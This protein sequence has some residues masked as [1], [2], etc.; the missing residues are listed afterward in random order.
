MVSGFRFIFVIFCFTAVLVLTVYLRSAKNQTF[1]KIC[2]INAEQNQLRQELW[3]R[4]IRLE[5]LMNPA[6]VSQCLDYIDN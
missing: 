6:A 2:T 4:Q 1:Y 3:Q 5:S